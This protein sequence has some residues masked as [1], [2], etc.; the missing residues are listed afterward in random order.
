MFFFFFF[1]W[2]VQ[3]GSRIR[4]IFMKRSYSSTL[5]LTDL[6]KSFGAVNIPN[7][8]QGILLKGQQ[9][10]GHLGSLSTFPVRCLKDDR[11]P[12]SLVCL[13]CVFSVREVQFPLSQLPHTSSG[14][15]GPSAPWGASVWSR[16]MGLLHMGHTLRISSHLSRHLTGHKQPA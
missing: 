4:S 6:T 13:M 9:Q 5:S 15:I 1:W 3:Y 10:G 2:T 11:C 7:S 14:S 16:R 12:S 8:H